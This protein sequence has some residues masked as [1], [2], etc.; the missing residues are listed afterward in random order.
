MQNR[1]RK[2]NYNLRLIQNIDKYINI[3]TTKMLLSTLVL[4]QLDYVN[5]ILTRAPTTTI[6]PY[7]TIQNFAARVAYKKSKRED[8]HMCLQELHLLPIKYRTTFKL[9]TIVY[10]TLHRN[11]PQYLREKLQWKKF[12]RLTR[13]STSSGVILDIPFNR[14]KSLANRGFSYTAAKYWT[15]PPWPHQDCRRHTQ[16]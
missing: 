5:S 10:N 11:A 15:W 14:K 12:P 1:L 2:A 6:K 13:Q 3:N 16:I 8:A 9:L 4:S 7:Q